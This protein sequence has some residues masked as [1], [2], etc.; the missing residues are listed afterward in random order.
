MIMMKGTWP[1]KVFNKHDRSIAP[2][3]LLLYEYKILTTKVTI[4]FNVIE[5]KFTINI[6]LN[7]QR[8]LFL[9]N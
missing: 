1:R 8:S 3:S 6:Q 9:K 7:S 4:I 2:V 5:S